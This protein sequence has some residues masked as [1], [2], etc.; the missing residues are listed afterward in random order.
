MSTVIEKLF[1]TLNV[2]VL[3]IHIHRYDRV[4]SGD[5]KCTKG[6]FSLISHQRNAHSDQ[7]ERAL[8]AI[9]MANTGEQGF[10]VGRG[11]AG[12]LVLAGVSVSWCWHCGNC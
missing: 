9:R 10:R 1:Q 3:H 12:A 11:A 7:N 6:M 2:S 4:P 8:H 5:S